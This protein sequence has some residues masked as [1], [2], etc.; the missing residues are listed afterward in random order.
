MANSPDR[1]RTGYLNALTSGY[2]KT[3]QDGRKV[4][5]PS[6]AMGRGYAIPSDEAYERLSRRIKIYHIVS[7]V[8]IV[9]AVAAKL[10]LIAFVIAGLSIAFYRVWTPYLVRGLQPSN[11]R[12]SMQESMAIQ[13]RAHG[14]VGLWLL[15]I[16]ALMFVTIG[17]VMLV[18]APDKR[19]IAF[20]SII[21][22][23]ACAAGFAHMLVLHRREASRRS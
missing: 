1:P 5:F 17:V 2:F 23:G 14:A 8:A 22:F 10:Y 13:A 12:L 9:G 7:L 11:E 21:F 15:E 3:A 18:V 19:L 4:F 6:G 20:T 16:V